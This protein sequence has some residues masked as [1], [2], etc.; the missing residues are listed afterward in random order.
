MYYLCT[1]ILGPKKF[2]Y[3]NLHTCIHTYIHTYIHTNVHTN[4]VR[5]DNPPK[6]LTLK[7]AQD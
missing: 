1:S 6:K 7:K 3:P 5:A 2:A 4:K